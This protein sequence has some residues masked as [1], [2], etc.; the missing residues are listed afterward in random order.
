M[1][2]SDWGEISYSG[3]KRCPAG[4]RRRDGEPEHGPR[5]AGPRLLGGRHRIWGKH[6]QPILAHKSVAGRPRPG[7]HSVV[8]SA[9]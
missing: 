5:H 3:T 9:D 4:P 1:A 8:G 7:C 2:L 6:I